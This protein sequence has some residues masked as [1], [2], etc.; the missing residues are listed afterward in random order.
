MDEKSLERVI[1]GDWWDLVGEVERCE[2]GAR[3]HVA[4][5]EGGLKTAMFA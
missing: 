3:K 4:D 1:S 5:D 2:G